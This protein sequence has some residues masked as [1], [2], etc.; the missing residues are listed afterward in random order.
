M[1]F[2][3]Q[4][5]GVVNTFLSKSEPWSHFAAI[6]VI[7]PHMTTRANP[8]PRSQAGKAVVLR[9][10]L[11]ECKASARAEARAR[12]NVGQSVGPQPYRV[13]ATVAARK[14][15]VAFPPGLRL[16][17]GMQLFCPSNA[18]PNPSIERTRS[19]GAGLAFIS[20]LAKP[21]P[22]PRAAHVKR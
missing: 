10:A 14:T 20:F 19:G 7:A 2:R 11:H 1:L 13:G 18:T 8:K 15:S 12:T 5:L 16:K 9:V 6:E 21:A 4:T 17:F 3:S 22:P